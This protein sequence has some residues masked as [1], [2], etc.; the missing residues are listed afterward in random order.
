[1]PPLEIC[2]PGPGPLCK[3]GYGYIIM[4]TSAFD[5][6]FSILFLCDVVHVT[7]SMFLFTDEAKNNIA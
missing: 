5:S 1:M 7:G 6:G 2:R 3:Y 4:V